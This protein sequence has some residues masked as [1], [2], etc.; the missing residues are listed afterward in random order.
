MNADQQMNTQHMYKYTR[1]TS[2][3]R[4]QQRATRVKQEFIVPHM[5]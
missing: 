4:P 3:E 5:G 1:G 2:K